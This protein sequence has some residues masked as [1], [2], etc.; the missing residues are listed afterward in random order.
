MLNY[1]DL[2]GRTD[3]MFSPSLRYKMCTT[4][5]VNVKT[6]FGEKLGATLSSTTVVTALFQLG[7]YSLIIKPGE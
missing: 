2:I 6:M 5:K 3:G 7:F 1:F 4:S